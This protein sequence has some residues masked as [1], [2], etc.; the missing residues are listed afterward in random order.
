MAKNLRIVPNPTGSTPYILFENTSGGKIQMN[1]KDDGSIVFSGATN[2]DDLFKMDANA[3][4]IRVGKD[5]NFENDIY[6][7]NKLTISDEGQ[8]VGTDVGV[9][10]N[11]GDLGP[12]G[13]Q[14]EKGLKGLR[15]SQGGGGDQGPTGD[16]FQGSTGPQ[17]P[18]GPT[19]EGNTKG[20]VGFKGIKGSQT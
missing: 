3:Q 18:Q 1:I 8:W 17:G 20:D 5:V 11:K 7:D 6:F 16:D 12:T 15:G 9:K 10:G 4:N 19:G 13:D 2:G 14:G